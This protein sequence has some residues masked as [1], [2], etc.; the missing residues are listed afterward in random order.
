MVLVAR[1]R[2]CWK[3]IGSPRNI[4][5]GSWDSMKWARLFTL[6]WKPSMFH[7]RHLKHF[8]LSIAS[9]ETVDLSE[10]LSLKVGIRAQERKEILQQIGQ[11]CW[12]KNPSSFHLGTE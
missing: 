4:R 7:V 9:A 2:S 3:S 5:S 10:A 11:S 12:Q 1:S 8:S 6:E